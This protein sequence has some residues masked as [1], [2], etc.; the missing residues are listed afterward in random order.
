MGSTR[1]KPT[2]TCSADTLAWSRSI[3]SGLSAISRMIQTVI[4]TAWTITRRTLLEIPR[5]ISAVESYQ[6][7]IELA[8][9]LKRVGSP[10]HMVSIPKGDHVW[11]LPFG[12]VLSLR[13][14]PILTQFLAQHL[15]PCPSLQQKMNDKEETDES[16]F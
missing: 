2:D 14:L 10:Y 9:E 15:M 1:R 12:S 16:R 4:S 3:P 8:D 6:Q 7:A 13:A 5:E 11:I